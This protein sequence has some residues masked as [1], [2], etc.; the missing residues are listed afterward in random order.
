M[1]LCEE[2]RIVDEYIDEGF[3]RSL[4][5]VIGAK[6]MDERSDEWPQVA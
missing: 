6:T 5:R 4:I 3:D 1:C 2:P